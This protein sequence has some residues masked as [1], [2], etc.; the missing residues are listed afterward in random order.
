[1]KGVDERR[2]EGMGRE[3]RER[4]EKK[5]IENRGER[6]LSR[7]FFGKGE[8]RVTEVYRIGSGAMYS[9][10]FSMTLM[11]CVGFQAWSILHLIIQ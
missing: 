1:M 9:L 3:G 2:E 7:C 5:R 11:V 10:V 4:G 6:D 8:S